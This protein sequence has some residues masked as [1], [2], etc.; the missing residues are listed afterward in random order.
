[1]LKFL[2]MMVA[3]D[4][5]GRSSGWFGGGKFSKRGNFPEEKVQGVRW[6]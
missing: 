3:V 6:I 5:N 2:K 4:H 1:M